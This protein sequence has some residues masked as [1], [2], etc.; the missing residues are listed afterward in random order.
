MEKYLLGID[1]GTSACKVT[2]FDERGQVK[3]NETMAYAVYYPKEGWA[4]Q[5]PKEWWEA[6][7]RAIKSVLAKGNISPG[8]WEWMARAGR[9]FFWTG[10]GRFL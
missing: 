2:V 9:R 1:V 5:D 7:C 10:M 8:P 4:E 6:V 3:A